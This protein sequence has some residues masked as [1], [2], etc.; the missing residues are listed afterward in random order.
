M[1]IS[2]IKIYLLIQ[3]FTSGK[4]IA[5]GYDSGFITAPASLYILWNLLV[6]GPLYRVARLQLYQL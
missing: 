2:V 6:Q 4:N 3:G 5:T 1:D